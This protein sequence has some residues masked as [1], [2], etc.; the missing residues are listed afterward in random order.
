MPVVANVT[1]NRTKIMRV[2]DT[3]RSSPLYVNNPT[4]VESIIAIV[5]KI[6]MKTREDL[7]DRPIDHKSIILRL[8]LPNRDGIVNHNLPSL[9]AR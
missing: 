3:G 4:M 2:E 1:E 8:V 9:Q 7:V 5:V 6:S